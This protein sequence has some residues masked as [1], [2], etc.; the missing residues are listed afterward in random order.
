V[1]EAAGRLAAAE[2]NKQAAIVEAEAVA[3]QIE[4][5]GQ[6]VKDHPLYLTWQWVKM[7]EERDGQTIYV[8]TEANLP[9]LEAGRGV[10]PAKG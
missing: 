1:A 7:M 3:K 2:A 8:P 9:I 5:I 6:N 10:T 4:I